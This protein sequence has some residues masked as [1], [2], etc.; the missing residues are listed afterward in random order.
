MSIFRKIIIVGVLVMLLPVDDKKQA[1]LSATA[2]RAAAETATFCQRNVDTCATGRELWEL[3]VQKAEYGIDLGARLV[4]AEIARSSNGERRSTAAAA[5]PEASGS[6]LDNAQWNSTD[7]APYDPLPPESAYP[8][9]RN[10]GQ[11]ENSS[12][13]R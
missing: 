8:S 4:R 7:R 13:W 9:R 5:I 6:K 1:Q 12:R 2:S 11:L 10:S 3:F